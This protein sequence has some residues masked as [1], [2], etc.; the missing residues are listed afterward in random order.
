MGRKNGVT[1][2]FVEPLHLGHYDPKGETVYILTDGFERLRRF[3]G[4]SEAKTPDLE[5][6]A[7]VHTLVHA[8]DAQHGRF[9]EALGLLKEGHAEYVTLNIASELGIDDSS[10]KLWLWT[11]ELRVRPYFSHHGMK[12][13]FGFDYGDEMRFVEALYRSGG[14]RLVAEVFEHP[15]CWLAYI[16]DASL[17][18]ADR[19]TEFMQRQK[20]AMDRLVSLLNK[21]E[22]R[23]LNPL[24]ERVDRYGGD[25]LP[26]L[27]SR[28]SPLWRARV[29]T[30]F[31]TYTTAE[32]SVE[33]LYATGAPMAHIWLNRFSTSDAAREYVSAA[34]ERAKDRLERSG[35]V[36]STMTELEKNSI[37]VDRVRRGDPPM[38]DY[39]FFISRGTFVVHLRGSGRCSLEDLTGLWK[40]LLDETS[41]EFVG[42]GR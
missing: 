37:L 33:E 10:V 7:L 27:D 28:P 16:P 14:S 15:P 42:P 41:S 23:T 20:E 35:Y 18:L 6:L 1:E 12:S 39:N 2:S 31:G 21:E 22:W 29:M 34:R 26:E 17:F 32:G 9:T 40:R 38:H 4:P 24:N 11:Q 19:E 13:D 30:F 36:S 5:R 8:L 25:P 3:G